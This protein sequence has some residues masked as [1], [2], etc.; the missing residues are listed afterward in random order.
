MELAFE[1]LEN[2][3]IPISKIK[4]SD[5]DVFVAA[6]MDEDCIKLLFADKVCAYL[7]RSYTRHLTFYSLK[8]IPDSMEPVLPQARPV[9]RSVSE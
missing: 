4:G 2:A 5:M 6:G 1:A 7:S 3:D 9:V 8:L